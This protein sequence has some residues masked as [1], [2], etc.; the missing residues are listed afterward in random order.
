MTPFYNFIT[1]YLKLHQKQSIPEL[2]IK[3]S[4]KVSFHYEVS[5]NINTLEEAVKGYR[6]EKFPLSTD[7][8]KI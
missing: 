8:K 1:Q 7:L 4:N 5:D 3:P 2:L 6:I